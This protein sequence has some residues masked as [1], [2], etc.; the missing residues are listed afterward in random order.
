MT[1][2]LPIPPEKLLGE[3]GWLRLLAVSLAGSGSADDLAQ[4]AWLRALQQ[5]PGRIH[6]LR[7]W[8]ATV[9]RRAWRRGKRD[10]IARLRRERAAARPEAAPSTAELAA[11]AS[12]HRTVVDAVLSLDEPG[13]STILLRFFDGRPPREIAR[14]HGV[15]VET[16]RTRLRRALAT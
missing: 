10:G 4:E 8:L 11:R 9:T 7:P 15:P 5:P 13:R 3:A 6:G 2:A 14:L 12:L 1:D 16:V